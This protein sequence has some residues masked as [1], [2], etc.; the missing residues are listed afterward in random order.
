MEMESL[1]GGRLKL[2]PT[3]CRVQGSL[4]NLGEPPIEFGVVLHT[5]AFMFN[6]VEVGLHIRPWD[7]IASYRDSRK[8]NVKATI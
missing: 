7:I 6:L 4:R 3:R 5:T 2:K 1:L 8:E